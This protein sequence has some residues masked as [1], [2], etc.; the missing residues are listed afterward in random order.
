MDF[1]PGQ[2]PLG[3]Q[4]Q[5][6]HRAGQRQACPSAHGGGSWMSGLSVEKGWHWGRV[7]TAPGV[8]G[9]GM[10]CCCHQWPTSCPSDP[11]PCPQGAGR[12]SREPL[13]NACVVL[14]TTESCWKVS[15]M[16]T[17]ATEPYGLRAHTAAVLPNP[18]V[19]VQ[20]AKTVHKEQLLESCAFLSVAAVVRC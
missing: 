7:W 5:L 6:G 14:G 18:L 11:P 4:G 10:G 13:S 2:C 20:P 12:C 19:R 15:Q 3:R 1:C 17:T 9:A 8:R 16:E